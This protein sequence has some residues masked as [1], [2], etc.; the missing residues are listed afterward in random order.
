[1][2][3]LSPKRH[4]DCRPVCLPSWTIKTRARGEAGNKKQPSYR[5]LATEFSRDGFDYRQITREGDA[6]IYEQ[7][8]CGCPDPSVCYEVIRIRFRD[9][10]HIDGRFIEPAEIYPHSDAWGIDGVTCTDKDSA[11]AKLKEVSA[12]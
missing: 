6:A 10:F 4:G 12:R 5:P 9:G 2:I 1:M 11:F 3:A 7:T 8:W